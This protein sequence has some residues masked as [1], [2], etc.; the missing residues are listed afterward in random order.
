MTPL[1]RMPDGNSGEDTQNAVKGA[2]AF[3]R[4]TN[5]TAANQT[6][7]TVKGTVKRRHDFGLH[8]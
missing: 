4:P 6:G 3:T 8:R 2:L 5:I 7:V 1:R